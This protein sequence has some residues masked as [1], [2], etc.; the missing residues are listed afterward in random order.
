MV[1]GIQSFEGCA[2]MYLDFRVTFEVGKGQDTA[3]PPE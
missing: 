2:Y 3:E 1:I